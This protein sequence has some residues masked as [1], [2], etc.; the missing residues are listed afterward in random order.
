MDEKEL[1]LESLG[2]G[3]VH[4]KFSYELEKVM[5]NINDENTDPE[6]LRKIDLT[7]KFKPAA[8]RGF[9]KIEVHSKA[10]LAPDSPTEHHVFS[11]IDNRG[12]HIAVIAEANQMTFDDLKKPLKIKEV[13]NA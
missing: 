2:H 6:K 12:K 9:I 8:D 4:E 11:G 13:K 10:E 3:V 5:A 7:I 1:T